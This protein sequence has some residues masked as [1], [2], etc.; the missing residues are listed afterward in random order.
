MSFIS[1]GMQSLWEGMKTLPA[2]GKMLRVM[3]LLFKITAKLT[4]IERTLIDLQKNCTGSLLAAIVAALL[5][6]A[7]AITAVAAAIADPE[8]S[9]KIGL[10]I[11][12]ISAIVAALVAIKHEIDVSEANKAIEKMEEEMH[13]LKEKKKE[14][15]DLLDELKKEVGK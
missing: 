15:G 13:D 3:E 5:A 7:A 1:V 11:S 6:V 12:A 2:V 8:P 10:V 9:T 4:G 14:L